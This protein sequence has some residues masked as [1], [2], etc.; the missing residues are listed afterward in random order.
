MWGSRLCPSR[1]M[2]VSN[3]V[4]IGFQVVDS[5]GQSRIDFLYYLPV[6]EACIPE[7]THNAGNRPPYSSGFKEENLEGYTEHL[8]YFL[9]ESFLTKADSEATIIIVITSSILMSRSMQRV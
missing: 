2:K 3:L 1:T 7:H 6:T 9:E 8:P 4:F 5:Q